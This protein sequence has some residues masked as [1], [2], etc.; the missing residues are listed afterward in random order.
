MPRRASGAVP[1]HQMH[2]LR[3]DRDHRV[4][5][6][7]LSQYYAA[8]VP[9]APGRIAPESDW[10]TPTADQVIHAV[11][12][13][14]IS[15]LERHRGKNAGAVVIPLT[16]VSLDADDKHALEVVYRWMGYRV[17]WEKDHLIADK[18][19]C[20]SMRLSW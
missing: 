3:L 4:F 6:T 13:L 20:W 17:S 11:N 18:G 2:Q 15:S 7:R 1:P 9:M 8:V 14:L 19:R 12:P 16:F 5:G 10:N